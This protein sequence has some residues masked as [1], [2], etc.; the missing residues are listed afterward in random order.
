MAATMAGAIKATV[1]ALGLGL[2]VYRDGAPTRDGKVIV[3]YPHVVVQEAIGLASEL[4]GDTGAHDEHGGTSEA[5]QVTL[6][7]RA[8]RIGADGAPAEVVE[9]YALADRLTVALN[10]C[11]LDLQRHAPWRVYGVRVQSGLRSGPTDNIVRHVLTVVVRRDTI[12]LELP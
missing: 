1:E 11:T 6:V 5:V 10:R 4:H 3:S 2:A 9:D 12:R 8:R 7:Q